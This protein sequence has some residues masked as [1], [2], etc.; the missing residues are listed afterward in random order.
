[1]A[2][3]LEDLEKSNLGNKVPYFDFLFGEGSLGSAVS[4]QSP[5]CKQPQKQQTVLCFSKKVNNHLMGFSKHLT[6]G[7][8][9]LTKKK[10]GKKRGYT[11]FSKELFYYF[12]FGRLLSSE[13]NKQFSISEVVSF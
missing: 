4:L 6:C 7:S 5:W 9:I 3:L 2:L 10:K 12:A 11:C 8:H 13:K 1:M